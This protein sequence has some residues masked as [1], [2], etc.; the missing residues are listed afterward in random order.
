VAAAAAAAG[1]GRGAGHAAAGPA[2]RSVRQALSEVS[3]KGESG[4]QV[5][6]GGG[7]PEAT[8]GLD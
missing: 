7:P 4:N 1:G 3:A 2:A 5:G 6:G 8:G